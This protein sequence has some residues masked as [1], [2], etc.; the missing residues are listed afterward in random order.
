MDDVRNPE[1]PRADLEPR[2]LRR[3]DVDPEPDLVAGLEE[4]DDAAIA[5][6]SFAPC[7]N[8]SNFREISGLLGYSL[9]S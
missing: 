7:E 3:V 2:A 5:G 6:E 8:P 4:G 1:Q 9:C